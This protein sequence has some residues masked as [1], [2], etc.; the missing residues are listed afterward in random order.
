VIWAAFVS[1]WIKLRR[2]RLLAATY[3]G[4]GALAALFTVLVFARAG[5]VGGGG[6]ERFVTLERL[7]K[8]D[9]LAQ[10]LSRAVGLLGVV[11]LSVTGAQMAAEYSNGTLRQLLVRQPRRPVLLAGKYLALVAFAVGAVL[12][13]SIT[14]SVAAIV[15][16]HVRGVPTTAWTS[17]TGLQLSGQALGNAVL[18]VVGY[19]SLGMVL[20]IIIRSPVAAVV[21]GLA[22]ILPLENIFAAVVNGSDHW[23][24]G[25]L[26]SAVADGGSGSLHYA[27]TLVKVAI[28]FAVGLLAAGAV[29]T[30]RDVTA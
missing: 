28:Y 19:A 25:Q 16:A 7:A 17:S 30:R 6:G 5:H 23:L 8:P 14:S 9:G 11:A 21:V 24:P 15:M 27:E 22:Y 18:A 2:P 3:V 26:L 12:A 29:F 10:G 20:G 13:A 4:L 1:E